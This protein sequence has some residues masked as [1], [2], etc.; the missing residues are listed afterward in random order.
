MKNRIC[1]CF[2]IVIA[3]FAYGQSSK[4]IIVYDTIT[5]YDTVF[6]YDT[7]K[8]ENK[9]QSENN[10][11]NNFT[12]EKAYLA[13][14]TNNF[15]ATLLLINKKDT[16]TISI[17]SIIL[18]ETNKNLD[19]M[20]KSLLTLLVSAA[21]TQAASAQTRKA[22]TL[23]NFKYALGIGVAFSENNSLGTT[24]KFDYLKTKKI[25]FG[26]R[27]SVNYMKWDDSSLPG[28]TTPG[29]EYTG[30]TLN[31][32]TGYQANGFLTSTYYLRKRGYSSKV[33]LFLSAGLGYE[34]FSIS[35]TVT[36][37]D[38][39]FDHDGKS[40]WGGISGLVCLGGDYKLGPG[41]FFF[42]IPLGISIYSM[43]KDE[44]VYKTLSPS[45]ET[46]VRRGF[47]LGLGSMSINLGYTFYF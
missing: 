34:T 36:Y 33:G 40:S 3:F 29:N 25:S 16:A 35:R 45:N 12:A 27:A 30:F 9:V 43:G 14:D 32:K 28:S 44:I 15:S 31:Y 6:V 2:F 21:L 10:F 1:F 8:V 22:D 18:S 26:G 11:K 23:G 38:N 42:D 20:K 46:F 5:V 37:T 17:N 4:T 19:A 41:K 39:K 13:I 24:I 47:D 7:I